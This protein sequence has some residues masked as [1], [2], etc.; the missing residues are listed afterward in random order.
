M[1]DRFRPPLILFPAV[2]EGEVGG[3]DAVVLPDGVRHAEGAQDF[4]GDVLLIGA[5]GHARDDMTEE[6]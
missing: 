2:A 1:E 4:P 6:S 5:A 3:R